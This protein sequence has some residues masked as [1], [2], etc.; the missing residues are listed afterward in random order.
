MNEFEALETIGNR[1]V[2][3][4]GE[5]TIKSTFNEEYELIE[6]QLKLG[7]LYKE[8]AKG[9]SELLIDTYEN[10]QRK[11]FTIENLKK[12]EELKNQIK[13]LENGK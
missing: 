1:G 7:A 2:H 3:D 11:I 10:P 5:E 9:I 13:E 4:W 12:F 6:R 8:L